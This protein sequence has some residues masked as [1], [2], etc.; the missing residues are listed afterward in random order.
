MTDGLPLL[1]RR[2]EIL[3]AGCR[4]ELMSKAYGFNLGGTAEDNFRP[5]VGRKFFYDLVSLMTVPSGPET[6][7]K[8]RFA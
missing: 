4:Y 8:G 2:I 6:K 3:P 5:L 7:K 1:N